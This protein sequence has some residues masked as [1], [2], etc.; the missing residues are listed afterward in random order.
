MSWIILHFQRIP[1]HDIVPSNSG[2]VYIYHRTEGHIWDADVTKIW[3]AD[4]TQN[5]EFGNAV[6]ID[7]NC[8]IAGC[9]LDDDEGIRTGSAYIFRRSGANSWTEEAKITASDPGVD[10]RFGISVDICED[11]A[12]VGSYYDDDNG[13]DSGSAYVYS[14]NGSDDWGEEIKLNASNAA[15]GD[16]FGRSVAINSEY[17]FVGSN[18]DD[19]MGTDSGAVYFFH[20]LGS[21][22]WDTGTKVLDSDGVGGDSFGNALAVYGKYTAVGACL[23]SS[24]LAG[25]V[26]SVSVVK[27]R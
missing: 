19:D 20:R 1:S 15:A 12:I 16:E 10:D 18:L 3:P 7:G 8:L 6:S 11:Y 25:T 14:Y 21:N 5:D 13:T 2:A 17:A 9:Y 27:Y 22:S 26:G 24:N 23:D 4:R